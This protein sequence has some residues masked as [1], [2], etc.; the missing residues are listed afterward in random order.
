MKKDPSVFQCKNKRHD[1]L[2]MMTLFYITLTHQNK[3]SHFKIYFKLYK[4][5]LDLAKLIVPKNE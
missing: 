1:Q 2:V 5:Q 3:I 4:I